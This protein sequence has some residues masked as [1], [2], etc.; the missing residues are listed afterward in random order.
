MPDR[1]YL[2]LS[3]TAVVSDG[4]CVATLRFLGFRVLDGFTTTYHTRR[5][6]AHRGSRKHQ[7]SFWDS[8]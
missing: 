5:S 4:L 8:S 1:T 3:T 6:A 2:F 7:T